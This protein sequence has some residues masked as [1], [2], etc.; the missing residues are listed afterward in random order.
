MASLCLMHSGL[1]HDVEG[2]T[3]ATKEP[4]SKTVAHLTFQIVTLDEQPWYEAE[5]KAI[6]REIASPRNSK[7][8]DEYCRHHHSARGRSGALS[9]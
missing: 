7:A 5:D 6:A 2:D 3:H 1:A 4:P 9:P 8:N